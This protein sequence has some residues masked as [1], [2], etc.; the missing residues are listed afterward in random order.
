MFYFL[1]MQ[2]AVANA[3]PVVSPDNSVGSSPDKNS[4]D[5][6]DTK[7]AIYDCLELAVIHERNRTGKSHTGLS[8]STCSVNRFC[9]YTGFEPTKHFQAS[10][11]TMI[12]GRYQV[13]RLG[14]WLSSTAMLTRIPLLCCSRY[15]IA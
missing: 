9:L 13:R 8:I 6:I 2:G 4:D 7:G 14:W 3:S 10:A 15:K 11:G 5:E 12:A 1:G